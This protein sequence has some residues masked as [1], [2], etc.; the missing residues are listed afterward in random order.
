MDHVDPL[1]FAPLLIVFALAFIV[2]LVLSRPS[3]RW[4]PIVVGEILAGIIIGQSGFEWVPNDNF[5]LQLLSDIGLAFLMFLAGMEI[6]FKLLL[7]LDKDDCNLLCGMKQVALALGIY[8]LTL[9]LAI[10]GS[11]SLNSIGMDSNPWLLAFVLSATS[12]G[13]LLPLL[14]S[15]GLMQ[16]K[17]GQ[18]IFIIASLA[19]FVTVILLTIFLITNESGLSPDIL[20]LALLG[21]AFLLFYRFAVNVTRLTKVRQVIEELSHATVQI[22]IRGAVTILLSFVVLAEFVQAELILGAFLAGLIIS[23]I[24]TNQDNEMVHKLEAFGFGFFVPIFF[25]MVGVNLN[26]RALFSSPKELIFIP[27]MLVIAVLVKM[28]PALLLKREFTWRQVFAAGI[29]LNTH[30]SIEV[31]VAVIGERSGLLSPQAST[32]LIVFAVLTVIAMP[33]IFNYMLPKTTDEKRDIII[34]YAINNLSTQVANQLIAESEQVHF[35]TTQPEL[36]Q[37]AKQ[38]G[39]ASHLVNDLSDQDAL[40]KVPFH[41]AK[42]VISLRTQDDSNLAWCRIARENGAEQVIA[43][44][45]DPSYLHQFQVAGINAF[46]LTMAQVTLIALMA[47]SPGSLTLLTDTSDN[48][49]VNEFIVQNTRALHTPL[50]RLRLPGDV[51]VLAIRREGKMLVP[52]GT[53]ELE[54]GDLISIVGSPDSLTETESLLRMTPKLNIGA[55]AQA[56]H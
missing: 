55:G 25:I 7:P 49:R 56:P 36:H 11:F 40:K 20:T 27:I 8:G 24:K 12:L 44:V 9:V 39:F 50:R 53:T 28:L 13:V 18:M 22:K 32:S 47:R 14:K 4:L 43:F 30:L 17:Y 37:K 54:F 26:L 23:L 46:T 10:T 45:T 51:L 41:R 6:D 16:T 52:H 2:P 1:R 31:A 21:I 15:G 42:S 19:D 3:F 35:V 33:V 5:T 29:I 38:D 34:I 48:F